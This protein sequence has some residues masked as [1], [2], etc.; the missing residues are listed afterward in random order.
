MFTNYRQGKTLNWFWTGFIV[1]V[2][3]FILAGSTNNYIFWQ[4][5]QVLGLLIFIKAGINLICFD[6]QNIYLKIIFILYCSWLLIIIARGFLFNYV[7][8]K[9]ILLDPYVGIFLYLAPLILLFPQTFVYY[10]KVF[11]VVF[12]FSIFYVIFD[13]LFIKELLNSDRTGLSGKALVE[14]FSE[15]SIPSCFILLTFSYHSKIKNLLAL[16]VVTLTIYFAILWGRRSLLFICLTP[17]IVFI[18][19]IYSLQKESFQL[20]Y[21]LHLWHL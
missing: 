15:L 17:V 6:I 9:N 12:I 21:C 8:F 16:A 11:S 18:F 14:T 2:L 10:R 19:Y 13:I 3:S 7:F 4:L 5:F 1:Y 20:F